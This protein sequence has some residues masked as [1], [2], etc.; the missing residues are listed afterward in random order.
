MKTSVRFAIAL[1][2]VLFLTFL[3][4]SSGPA[5]ETVVET[6]SNDRFSR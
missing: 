5:P 1:L 3:A 6:I 2:G 4:N